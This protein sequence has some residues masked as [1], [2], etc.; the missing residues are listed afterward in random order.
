MDIKNLRAF[1]FVGKYGSLPRAANYLKLTSP[2]IS[3]QL[4]KLEKEL[5]VKLFDRYPNKLVLT[6]RGR[7]LLSDVSRILDSLSKLQDVASQVPDLASEKLTI[8]LGSD[9][10]KFLAPQIAVFSERHPRFQLT[11][12]SKPSETLSLL[13][14]G[15]VDVAIGWFPQIPRTL[16]RQTL[17]KSS[18]YLIF[19]ANHLLTRRKRIVLEDVAAF[20]LILPSSRTAA[21]RVV[22]SGFYSSGVEIKNILEVGSCE[23]IVEFVRRNIGIGFVHDI[24]F[25]KDGTSDIQ[26]YDMGEEL[27]RLEVSLV[28]KESVR[29]QSAYRAL[30]DGFCKRGRK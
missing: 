9:L 25:P 2:A 7:T 27:G 21:R 8:A 14:A 5:R 1:Y 22:D 29:S 3:V 4:K 18:L 12:L 20:S 30:I 11:I 26:S 17:F 16:T 6:D 19:P 23:S 28:Y 15:T 10:A 13:L 24:C